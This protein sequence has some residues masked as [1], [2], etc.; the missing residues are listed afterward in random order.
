M[1]NKETKLNLNIYTWEEIK[2]KLRK[3]IIGKIY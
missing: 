2:K 1:E 3:K